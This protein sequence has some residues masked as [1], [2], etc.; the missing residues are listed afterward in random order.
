MW[1]ELKS[2]TLSTD[3]TRLPVTRGQLMAAQKQTRVLVNASQQHSETPYYYIDDGVLMRSWS[4]PPACYQGHVLF[5]AHENTWSGH[6]GVRKTYDHV[7]KRFFWPGME[8]DITSHCR[9]CCISQLAGK[10]NQVILPAPLH[11]ILAVG[12]PFECALV[13]CVGP[14]PQSKSKSQYLLTI[15]CAFTLFPAAV[16]SRNITISS[17]VRAVL[18]FFS[19]S[20]CPECCRLT[21][22]LISDPRCLNK[23]WTP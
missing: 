16:P 1:S 19:T 4:S 14:L 23:F 11:P 13:E 3:L 18:K 2:S 6:L 12:E 9:S 21:R 20:G 5:L 17:V 8:A 10:L 15:M 7:L 22:A